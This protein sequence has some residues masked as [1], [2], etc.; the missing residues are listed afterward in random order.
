MQANRSGRI[1][2]WLEKLRRHI[3]SL[4]GRSLTISSRQ[5]LDNCNTP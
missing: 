5:I 3:S 1:R 4:G 2:Q